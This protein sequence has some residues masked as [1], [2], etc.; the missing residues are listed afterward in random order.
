MNFKKIILISKERK[1]ALSIIFIVAIF[2]LVPVEIFLGPKVMQLEKKSEEFFSAVLP[3]EISDPEPLRFSGDSPS[4]IIT[5]DGVLKFTNEERVKAGLN[6]LKFSALL[7]K[8]ASFKVDDMFTLQY[9]AHVSPEGIGASHL[10]LRAGYQ[11]IVIGENLAL[12]NFKDDE[13]LVR[14]WMASPGHR[15]NILNSRYEEIGIALK[16]GEFEG[17]Q[18]WLAVQ[19]FGVPASSCRSPNPALKKLIEENKDKLSD[20]EVVL[21]QKKDE[22]DGMKIKRGSTY[23]RKVEEY[24]TLVNE[25]NRLIRISKDL[26][27]EFNV[28]VR[29]YNLC[30]EGE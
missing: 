16:K 26:I 18:R 1:V 8:A 3:K 27:A 14:A 21:Q 9:F 30:V 6:P 13:E 25:Y 22:I 20:L 10:A 15:A 19:T 5:V 28:E 2:A 24:N 11:F 29:R 17:S 23:N 12:G 7:S 4:S